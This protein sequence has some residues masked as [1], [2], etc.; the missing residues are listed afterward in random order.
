MN[1]V[2]DHITALGHETRLLL[3]DTW[4]YVTALRNEP[5]LAE[6]PEEV[7]EKAGS[8]FPEPLAETLWDYGLVE[9]H[10]GRHILEIAAVVKR[11]NDRITKISEATG[12]TFSSIEPV[13]LALARQLTDEPPYLLVYQSKEEQLCV[14]GEGETVWASRQASESISEQLLRSL[15]EYA[16]TQDLQVT[17]ILVHTSRQQLP[18]EF[19]GLPLVKVELDPVIST[20]LR[21]ARK[22]SDPR[23]IFL[24]PAQGTVNRA[25]SLLGSL[26]RFFKR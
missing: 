24:Q 11:F 26:T 20:A 9:D 12:V 13:S 3:S 17:Q 5:V 16:L 23:S 10:E 8:F 19:L 15:L 4:T 21:Q 25:S 22:P 7:L 1:E 6:S 14:L 18:A 2:G